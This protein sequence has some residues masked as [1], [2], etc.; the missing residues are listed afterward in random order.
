M[1]FI[2]SVKP[3]LPS[4][5][6]DQKTV[7]EGFREHWKDKFFNFSRIEAFHENVQVEGRYLALPM[8][9]YLR[10]PNFEFRNNAWIRVSLELLEKAIL[11]LLEKVSLSPKSVSLIATTSSTG[12]AVPSLEARLMN[13]IPFSSTTKRLPLFGLGCLAGVA[14]I[15]RIADYLRGYPE[16]A[17]LLL[18]TELCSLTLQLQDFS[19]P[20]LISTGLFGDG[21]AAV[22]LVGDRHPLAKTAPLEIVETHSAFFPETERIMGWDIIDSGFKIVLDSKVPEVVLKNFPR[23]VAELLEIRTLTLEDLNFFIAHSGGPK[24]LSAIEE[25]MHLSKGEL[26]LSWESLRKFG[27]LS[28]ASVLFVLSEF[29]KNP[30]PPNQWGLMASMGPA[31]CA[32]LSLLKS[33]SIP[34]GES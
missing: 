33:K 19:I 23:I 12:I 11:S 17:A 30:A 25:S 29:L 13:R 28:S 26:N 10:K 15:N 6:Y 14:G 2:H 1:P 9:E 22:L 16:E 3:A 7:I 18:S 34:S 20:N 24:V 5:Y 21:A 4:H 8:E 32:E 31:F 27:N